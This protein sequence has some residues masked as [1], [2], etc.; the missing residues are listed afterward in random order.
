MNSAYPGEGSVL[1]FAI[2]GVIMGRTLGFHQLD[3]DALEPM[4]EALERMA[5][6]SEA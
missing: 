6:K 4:F 1:F 5:R 2:L 3:V